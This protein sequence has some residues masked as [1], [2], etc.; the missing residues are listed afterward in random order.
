MA[1][2]NDD[3][4]CNTSPSEVSPLSLSAFRCASVDHES[5]RGRRFEPG[6]SELAALA[7]AIDEFRLNRARFRELLALGGSC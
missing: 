7:F 1:G 5:Q 6:E 3:T 4:S 2:P